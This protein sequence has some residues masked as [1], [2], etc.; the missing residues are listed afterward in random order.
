MG[1]SEI[2]Q[3]T[4]EMGADGSM[5]AMNEDAAMAEVMQQIINQEVGEFGALHR[6]KGKQEEEYCHYSSGD[7]V[8]FEEL[9]GNQVRRKIQAE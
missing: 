4:A 7:D 6:P 1:D 3:G 2:I 5:H 8:T 9:E